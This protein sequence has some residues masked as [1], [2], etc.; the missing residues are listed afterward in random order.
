[1][2]STYSFSYFFIS[3]NLLLQPITRLRKSSNL[4]NPEIVNTAQKKV[5]FASDVMDNEIVKDFLK[6]KLCSNVYQQKNVLRVSAGI[7]SINLSLL[8]ASQD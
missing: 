7:S 8:A 5:S 2:K 1:M 6:V 3:F 4:K